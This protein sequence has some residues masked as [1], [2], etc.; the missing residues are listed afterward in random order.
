MNLLHTTRLQ[1]A[2]FGG[3]NHLPATLAAAALR[4]CRTAALARLPSSS[5]IAMSSAAEAAPA[6]AAAAEPA[7]DADSPP[8]S[9]LEID[10]DKYDEQLE[11]KTAKI[12]Q[13]FSNFKT[14]EIE[15][16][17][18]PPMH[19]RQRA[20]LAVWHDNGDMYYIMYKPVPGQQRP[21]RT[22]VDSFPVASKLI[23]KLMVAVREH[24]LKHSILRE[25]LFQVGRCQSQA[26]GSLPACSRASQPAAGSGRAGRQEP[27]PGRVLSASSAQLHRPGSS[28]WHRCSASQPPLLPHTHTRTFGRRSTCTARCHRCSASQPPPPILPTPAAQVNLHSTL[29]GDAMVTLLYHK[30][31][32]GKWQEAAAQL[33][34]QVEAGGAME[35][36][37]TLA[38]IGRARKQKLE[39]DRSFVIEKM[40]VGCGLR[41]GSLP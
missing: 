35:E 19:Y 6:K 26:A 29:A 16:H 24:V 1:A 25:R 28:C 9:V 5:S 32:D 20:E 38:I 40:Q 18:S 14:P 21:Q 3:L 15:V 34:A 27:Q 39:L 37:G 11:S 7:A 36:G 12:R 4:C 33:K 8:S 30:K 23:N 13:Q 41:A 2:R 17:T 22:R 10:P 31:L